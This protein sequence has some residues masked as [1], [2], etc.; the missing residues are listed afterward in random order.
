MKK[1]SKHSIESLERMSKS[2]RN[3]SDEIRKKMSKSQ[4]GNT[5]ALGCRWNHTKEWKEEMSV[6]MRGNKYGL[7]RK[8]SDEHK[9][10]ISE[11]HKK[12]GVGKWMLGRKLS[13][14][15]RA[16]MSEKIVSEETKRKIGNA[17]LG[18]K[19]CL[20]TQNHIQ[21]HTNEAKQKMS[22]ARRGKFMGE[23][24]PNWKG[25]ITPE[26]TK[27]RNSI[28]FQLWR[29]AIF[30]RDNFTCQKYGIRGC[31]LHA[32]HIQ[33]FSQ[34]PELRFAIDNGITLSDRA[35]KEFHQIYGRKNNT[36]EQLEEFLT[37]KI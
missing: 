5:N 20:G 26:N 28:D 6:K 10:K 4:K 18:N 8:L 27:V 30:A 37:I 29:G 19:H 2:H 7:G 11:H 9:H 36:R 16:K 14:E 24:S 17:Q 34:Y 31:V 3:V 13:D 21:K 15:T 35:H 12:T 1:G 23:K 22:L 25:G 33:N 32:H